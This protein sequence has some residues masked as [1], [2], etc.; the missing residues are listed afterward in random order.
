MSKLAID[1]FILSAEAVGLV[2]DCV[3]ISAFVC[4]IALLGISG[5]VLC[6]ICYS[7]AVGV[8]ATFAMFLGSFV[9]YIFYL[10]V[11][12][13]CISYTFYHS[14]EEAKRQL[15]NQRMK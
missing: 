10:V 5:G 11:A 12:C 6:T 15:A 3:V 8:P 1:R 13:F 14:E 9:F 2:L 4:A 7:G